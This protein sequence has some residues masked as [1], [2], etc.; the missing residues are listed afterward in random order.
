MQ[1]KSIVRG[2]EDSREQRDDQRPE[3]VGRRCSAHRRGSALLT[4]Q[5]LKPLHRSGRWSCEP[6]MRCKLGWFSM[7]LDKCRVS[8]GESAETSRAG[9]GF[10]WLWRPWETPVVVFVIAIRTKILKSLGP[11][12]SRH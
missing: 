5:G 7:A 8:L 2:A 12:H 10:A 3:Q 9:L 6:R 1:R 11:F 4:S